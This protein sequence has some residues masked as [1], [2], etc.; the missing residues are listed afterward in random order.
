LNR[1]ALNY[2][3]MDTPAQVS[4]EENMLERHLHP[5]LKL[6]GIL[7]L[8]AALSMAAPPARKP[9]VADPNT[10]EGYFLQLVESESN[11]NTKLA[12]LEKFVVQFPKFSSLDSVYAEIQSLYA[13]A[14]QLDK[15]I[16]AGEKLLAIDPQDIEGA[17]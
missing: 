6:A 7:T 1:A 15:A 16:V 4:W 17:Q 8:I 3:S 11:E 13:S 2:Y 12:L 9:P 5:A 10:L 14:G